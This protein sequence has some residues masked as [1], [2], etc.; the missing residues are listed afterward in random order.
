METVGQYL[1]AG[2]EA[3]QISIEEVML[4]TRIQPH[5]I[6]ALEGDR[7]DQLPNLV[8]AKGFI[9]SYARFLHLD[10]VEAFRLFA[11]AFPPVA[12]TPPTDLEKSLV[13]DLGVIVGKKT[14]DRS[15]YLFLKIFSVGVLLLFFIMALISWWSKDGEMSSDAKSGSETASSTELITPEGLSSSTQAVA[16]D[17]ASVQNLAGGILTS[18]SSPISSTTGTSTATSSHAVLPTDKMTLLLEV[19]DSTWVK[20]VIDGK[21]TRDALLKRGDKLEWTAK[22]SFNFTIGN[23]GGA[24]VFLDGKALGFL[25]KKGEVVKNRLLT[26]DLPHHTANCLGSTIPC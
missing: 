9:R 24:K 13:S 8:S 23:A 25:G 22:K 26:R 21:D 12:P 14:P 19:I 1:R 17:T 16:T 20:V 6:E 15:F 4:H 3:K 18:S 5:F 10:E 2:R 7:F 11:S